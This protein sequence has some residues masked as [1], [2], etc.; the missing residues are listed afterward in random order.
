MFPAFGLNPVSNHPVVVILAIRL[1]AT[2]PTVVNDPPTMIFPSLC[3]TRELT[4]LF[5]FGSK[6]VSTPPVVVIL[7][8]RL[9]AILLTQV[10]VQ[11]IMICPSSCRAR[12]FITPLFIFGL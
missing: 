9:R 6:L 12:E 2:P 4:I 3:K 1:R 11:P 5:E 7:A 10:N 8:I